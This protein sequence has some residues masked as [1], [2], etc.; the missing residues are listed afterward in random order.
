MDAT[1][2]SHIENMFNILAKMDT[3]AAPKS[4]T[5]TL[6]LSIPLP[7]TMWLLTVTSIRDRMQP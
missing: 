6:N 2:R 1:I 5:I 3:S 4:Q 7:Q